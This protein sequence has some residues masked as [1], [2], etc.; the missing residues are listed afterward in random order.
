M[1]S[2]GSSRFRN[3]QFRNRLSRFLEDITTDHP[4]ESTSFIKSDVRSMPPQLSLE[5][6]QNFTPIEIRM[7]LM[8][9]L[10]GLLKE[11]DIEFQEANSHR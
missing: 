2:D 9:P 8:S 3:H 5:T 1:L 6:V 4:G 10:L 7:V 11:L